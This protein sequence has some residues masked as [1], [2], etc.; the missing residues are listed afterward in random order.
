MIIEV[1]TKRKKGGVS[2]A[3]D[4]GVGMLKFSAEDEGERVFL[5]SLYFLFAPAIP[6]N[7]GCKRELDAITRLEDWLRVEHSRINMRAKE[8]TQQ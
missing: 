8:V 1:A 2:D 5:T 3:D 6:R 7:E 4:R